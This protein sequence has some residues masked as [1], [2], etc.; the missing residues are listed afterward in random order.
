MDFNKFADAWAKYMNE[1]NVIEKIDEVFELI[2]GMK[3]QLQNASDP[4]IKELAEEYFNQ[5]VDVQT[6]LDDPEVFIDATND[7][8]LGLGNGG[9]LS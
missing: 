5:W 7:I 2:S 3:E 1:N 6:I 9:F 4:Y 8:I